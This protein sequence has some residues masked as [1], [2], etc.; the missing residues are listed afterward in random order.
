MARLSDIPDGK[1]KFVSNGHA[2]GHLLCILISGP[3][4]AW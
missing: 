1:I 4:P 2:A 3:N